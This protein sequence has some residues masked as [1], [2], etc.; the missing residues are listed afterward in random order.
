M[1]AAA[2]QAQHQQKEPIKTALT[3]EAR[4]LWQLDTIS[5]SL[6]HSLQLLLPTSLSNGQVDAEDKKQLQHA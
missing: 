3:G 1:L 6:P 4:C 5:M 2:T